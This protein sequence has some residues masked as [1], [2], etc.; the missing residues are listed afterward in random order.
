[1]LIFDGLFYK[2]IDFQFRP[3]KNAITYCQKYTSMPLF[4]QTGCN[5]KIGLFQ[6]SCFAFP[7]E[8]IVRMLSSI[9]VRNAGK[10]S[11]R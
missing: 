11:K 7:P 9:Y 1:M 4:I 8:I 5:H 6:I 3:C 10:T 2:H